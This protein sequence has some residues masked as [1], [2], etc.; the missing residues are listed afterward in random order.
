MEWWSQSHQ[1]FK[2]KVK[3]VD[4][5]VAGTSAYHKLLWDEE[6]E[7]PIDPSTQ[8]GDNS[9]VGQVSL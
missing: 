2:Q 6:K 5:V 8:T 7:Q 9:T 1:G 3:E 4:D